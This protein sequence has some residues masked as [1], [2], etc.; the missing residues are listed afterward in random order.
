MISIVV[1]VLPNAH[2]SCPAPIQDTG[3][4]EAPPAGKQT[5]CRW[6]RELDPVASLWRR[7]KER[8]QEKEG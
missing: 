4:A 6:L 1:L 8:W 3:A 7:G 2:P 5:A